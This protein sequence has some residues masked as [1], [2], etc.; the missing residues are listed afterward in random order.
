MFYRTT[1]HDEVEF[2]FKV[3]AQEFLIRASAKILEGD[4]WDPRRSMIELM[5]DVYR[6]LPDYDVAVCRAE[7]T[8]KEWEA[9]EEAAEL[10]LYAEYESRVEDAREERRSFG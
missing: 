9:I 2:L 5:V 3:R 1:S 6:V 8:G 7:F 10:T 4:F